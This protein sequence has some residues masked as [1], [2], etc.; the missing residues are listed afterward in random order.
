MNV[1]QCDCCGKIVKV[2]DSIFL[3]ANKTTSNN[4][5]GDIIFKKDICK[6]CYRKII[7]MFTNVKG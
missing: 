7:D 6:E 3:R 2:A 5:I 4:G 1:N